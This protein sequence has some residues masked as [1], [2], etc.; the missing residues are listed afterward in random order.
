MIR[1][2][3]PHCK[4]TISAADQHAGK[5]APCPGCKS[6]VTVPASEQ[7]PRPRQ[8]AAAEPERP[9]QATV[10]AKQIPVPKP[11]EAVRPRPAHAGRA[12][13]REDDDEVTDVEV[14]EDEDEVVDVEVIEDDEEEAKPRRR[15]RRT[16]EDDEEE[17]PRRRRRRRGKGPRTGPYEPCPNCGEGGDAHR[18]NWTLWGGFVGPWVLCHVRCNTCDTTYNGRT[19]DYNTTGIV[20]WVVI[21][22]V[23]GAIGAIAAIIAQGK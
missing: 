1:F 12:A 4:R 8:A 22:A 15:R 16:A 9:R 3:C 13:R 23:L 18:V 21:P 2:V 20:L 19:G 5:Q 10:R 6:V 17:R 7:A 11:S 14:I